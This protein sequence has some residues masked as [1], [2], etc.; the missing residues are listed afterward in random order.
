MTKKNS[1]I[2][3]RLTPQQREYLENIA[4]TEGKKMSVI[5][6]EAIEDYICN[7]TNEVI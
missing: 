7:Y 4:E 3:V 1:R 6:R 2:G 5:I